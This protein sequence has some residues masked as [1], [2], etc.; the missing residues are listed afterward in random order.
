MSDRIYN[1]K[2]FWCQRG[3]NINLSD[4]G[5]LSDP[6]SKWGHIFNPKVVSFES[7]SEIPCLALLG[8]PGIGKSTEM[9][10]QWKFIKNQVDEAGEKHLNFDLREYQTDV[11][12]CQEIFKS[13]VFQSWVDGTHQLHLFLDSL[14]EGLLS[15]NTLATLLASKFNKYPVNR[16]SLC[17][18]CRTADWPNILENELKKLW[19]DDAVKVYELAPLRRMD[20]VEAAKT[21]TNDLDSDAFL[22]EIEYKKVVP[23]AIKPITLNFLL[24]T[25][26]RNSQLPSTQAELYLEGCRLLCEEISPSRIASR[27]TGNLTTK[28]RM[29]VAA[30]IAAVTVFANRYAVWTGVDQGDVPKE[31]VTVQKLCGGEKMLTNGDEFE[32]SENAVR[33]ALSISGL[34]S[35]RGQNRMGWAHQTYAEFLAS[36]YIKQMTLTQMMSLIFHQK[37]IVPQLHETAAWLSGMNHDVFR[38]IMNADPEV[39]LQ[40][41]A[42]IADVKDREALVGTLL[43]LYDEEKLLDWKWGVR[44]HYKKLS[45]PCLAEQLRPY[46]CERTKGNIVRQVAINIAEACE[47]QILQ[48]DL[49]NIALDP[50]QPQLIRKEAACAIS[51]IGDDVTKVKLKPLVFGEAG[52]DPDDELK[53]YGLR[54]VWPDHIMLEELFAVLTPP[55]EN[56]FYRTYQHFLSENLVQHIQPTDLPLALKW[57]E[58]Q[59]SPHNLPHHF[60]R[61]MDDIMLQAWEY[62]ELPDVL[63]DFAKVALSRLEHYVAII[64]SG[65][66]PPFRKIWDNNDEKRHRVIEAIV[67]LL[68]PIE[69]KLIWSIR[70]VILDRDIP[71]MIERLQASKSEQEQQVWA[72]LIRTAFNWQESGQLDAVL[73]ACENSLILAKEFTWLL[74]PVELNSPKAQGMKADYLE[75]Q[76]WEEQKQPLLEPPPAKRIVTLLDKCESGNSAAWWRLTMEMT[77]EP[78]S[79]HYDDELESDLTILPGW[80]EA[81]SI[82]RA[83]IVKAAE[84]YVL[85]QD[86]ETDEWLGTNILHR[87]AFA[88]YKAL[89]LLLQEASDS[90]FSISAKVWKKWTPIIL[91]YPDTEGKEHYQKLIKMAYDHA[92]D[93]IIQTLMLLIDKE[94]REGDHI[95]IID[96][97]EPCWDDRLANTLLVKVKDRELNPNC[98]GCLLNELLKNEVA[99]AKLFAETLIPLPPPSGE[100]ERLEAIVATHM[101]MAHAEDAGWSV[102]WPAIQQDARFGQD[103][104]S[105]VSDGFDRPANSIGQKLTEE[106]AADLYLWLV[107]QYPYAEDPKYEGFHSVGSRELIADFRDSLLHHLKERGTNQACEAIQRIVDKLPELKWV[108][109]TLLEAQDIARRKTWLPPQ[110]DDILK[111]AR[112]QKECLVQNGDH[113]LDVLIESLKRLEEKLQ[114]ET[115]AATDLWNEIDKNIYRPKDENSL[116]DYVKRHLDEELNPKGIILAREVEIR[117]GIGSGNG[118]RTDI[119]VDTVVQG[120]GKVT[121]IIEVK[122]CWH[123]DL[124]HAMKTQL[125]ERYLKDNFCQHGLYLIG[126]FNCKQWDDGDYRKK[127]SS[128]DDIDE[129]QKRFNDQAAELSQQNMQI[130][131]FVLNTALR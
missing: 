99:E 56:S 13:P 60:E 37:K 7:L 15:I 6:D 28:Q 66:N 104:I 1:W 35:S 81:D 98:M 113:L 52:D 9:A 106:Q 75:S 77:L 54:A 79:T 121:V 27:R 120:Y 103:V 90:L 82:T 10:R 116:S 89:R 108:K 65:T 109:R 18:A 124:D 59:G 72:Q 102:V 25:Y 129:A 34:F 111:M 91:A 32:V 76:N 53:G 74:E 128:G 44:G 64:G 70:P 110:P 123:T 83:R 69:E 130:K 14:D 87:P 19:G 43:R 8:E 26:C 126:W 100:K 30:R 57:V 5:Y 3:A 97:V 48:D 33:E 24:N 94:N 47:L 61:L 49:A 63:E 38:E 131:A 88:G 51:R 117:R 11:E 68:L 21:K 122:G 2:R 46:I 12:L 105:R 4:G 92:P 39:L 85:E 31:D 58:E 42:V 36:Y 50:S 62:L 17:V 80:K 29:A 71:W 84:R 119:H 127:K 118:E 22:H 114:G 112:S 86:P 107:H 115:P 23:L 78:D 93:E 96:K 45:H 95:S 20:V 73:F 67:S 101:L 41:A 16:L 125:M 40:S 55:N